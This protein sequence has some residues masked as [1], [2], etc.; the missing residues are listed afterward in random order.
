MENTSFHLC[1][2]QKQVNNYQYAIKDLDTKNFEI[3]ACP[4]ILKT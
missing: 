1:H 4:N 2:D 3:F